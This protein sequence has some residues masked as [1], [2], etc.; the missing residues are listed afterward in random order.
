MNPIFFNLEKSDKT[1][2]RAHS[3][4]QITD[5][6]VHNGLG[7]WTTCLRDYIKNEQPAFLIHT[8][9][10]CYEYSCKCC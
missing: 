7:I 10:I 9:D 5:T 3:F 6:E 8:G 2:D 4:I 1:K